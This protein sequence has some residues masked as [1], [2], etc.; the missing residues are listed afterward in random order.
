MSVSYEVTMNVVQ[1]IQV[2]VNG[3]LRVVI[4]EH[5]GKRLVA[6]EVGQWYGVFHASS[7][8]S[9]ATKVLYG[10]HLVRERRGLVQVQVEELVVRPLRNCIVLYNG[11]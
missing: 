2:T 1:V 7:A 9:N 5:V 6:V 3:S 11:L 8:T 4:G 10:A